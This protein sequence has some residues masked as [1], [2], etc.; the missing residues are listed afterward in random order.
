MT[1]GRRE[2]RV[3][4]LLV[5]PG[6]GESRLGNAIT[7]R[8]DRD[9]RQRRGLLHRREQVFDGRGRVVGVVGRVVDDDR[10]AGGDRVRPLDVERGLAD[11][12]E[13]LGGD[14][15]LVHD[16]EAGRSRNSEEL[17]EGRQV[18]RE[19][20]VDPLFDDGDRLAGAVAGDGRAARAREADLVDA[21]GLAKLRRADLA[22]EERQLA[23][24]DIR[25]AARS[26]NWLKLASVNTSSFV[27][28]TF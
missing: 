28:A 27:P 21:V 15:V 20:G 23:G 11:D 7:Q 4:R 3:E 5:E 12:V 10:R 9:A 24:D 13:V 26:T 18:G 6:R 25:I 22:A 8:D 16:L 2:V 1:P 14:S 19:R 17:V